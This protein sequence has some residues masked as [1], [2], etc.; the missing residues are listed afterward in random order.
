MIEQAI[1]ISLI[2]FGVK[3][4]T[5]DGQIFGFVREWVEYAFSFLVG[6][7]FSSKESKLTAEIKNISEQIKRFN[8]KHSDLF[9]RQEC[10]VLSNDEIKIHEEYESMNSVKQS[11]YV[12]LQK[13]I[14]T[15]K[16]KV[17]FLMKPIFVC[18]Y[19]MASFWTITYLLTYNVNPFQIDTL[20]LM[21]CTLGFNVL[22]GHTME[23]IE[24]VRDYYVRLR[25]LQG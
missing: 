5:S 4:A 1:T 18:T 24:A 16:S 10:M 20:W 7:L 6:V 19:C 3:Y 12:E 15:I 23:G 2:C 22:A 14:H 11:L 13:E 25:R 8:H 9:D 21:A 17:D